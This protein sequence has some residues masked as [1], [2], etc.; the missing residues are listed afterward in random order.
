MRKAL[1]LLLCSAFIAIS[2]AVYAAS[3]PKLTLTIQGNTVTA[4]GISPG[5]TAIFVGAARVPD[6]RAYLDRIQRWATA[7]D[8]ADHDGVVALT[9]PADVP[10]VS[11]WAVADLRDGEYAMV[12]GPRLGFHRMDLGNPMRKSKSGSVDSLLLNR[13]YVELVYVKPGLGALQ[14]TANGSSA[15]DELVANVGT[16]VSIGKGNA[17]HVSGQRPINFTPGGT[18]IAIDLIS[19][20]VGAVDIDEALIRGAR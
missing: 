14:W 8:D 16:I 17:L 4:T 6:R 11:L 2:S 3:A 20:E 18:L 9:L 12:N 15:S 1:V 7:V 5:S 10:P 13:R 19:M